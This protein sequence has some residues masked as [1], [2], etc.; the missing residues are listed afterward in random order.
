MPARAAI[1]PGSDD[2]RDGVTA[3]HAEGF[4]LGEILAF[5]Q[6]DAARWPAADVAWKRRLAE[7][8]AAGGSTF[9]AYR[10]KLELAEDCLSRAVTPLDDDLGAWL[11]FLD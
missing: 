6:I 10:V 4:A 2:S 7:D 1:P 5:E 11:A 8:G 9:N 3:A